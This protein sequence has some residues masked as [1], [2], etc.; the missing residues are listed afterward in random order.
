MGSAARRWTRQDGLRPR[1]DGP[2]GAV[3][4]A[5]GA[6]RR[7]GRPAG[8]PAGA[9]AAWSDL[10]VVFVGNG[11]MRGQLERRSHEL[12]VAWAVRFLGDQSGMP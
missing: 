4:R 7:R 10:R 8:G 12:G 2:G 3:R 9:A 11:P 1:A 5:A 6:R